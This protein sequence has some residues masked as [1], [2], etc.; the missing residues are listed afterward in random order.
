MS[1]SELICLKI[2][3]CE[4]FT[5]FMPDDVGMKYKLTLN[6]SRWLYAKLFKLLGNIAGVIIL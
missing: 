4:H 6:E 1:N 2:R 3:I 5:N